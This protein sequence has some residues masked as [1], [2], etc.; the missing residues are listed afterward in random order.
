[1]SA[2]PRPLFALALTFAACSGPDAGEAVAPQGPVA[3]EGDFVAYRQQI[4]G[5]EVAFAMVPIPAG[6]PP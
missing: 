5:S 4:P 2:G 1:M 3:G 6:S